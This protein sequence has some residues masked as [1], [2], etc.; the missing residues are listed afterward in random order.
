MEVVQVRL[1]KHVLSG[2]TSAR[3]E[4]FINVDARSEG[5]PGGKCDDAVAESH[6]GVR[7]SM[8]GNLVRRN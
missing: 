6:A 3:G 8:R 1:I 5:Q 2:L 7:G 4:A